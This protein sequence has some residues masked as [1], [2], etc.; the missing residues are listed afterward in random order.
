MTAKYKYF[1]MSG[2]CLFTFK[3][4]QP[5]GSHFLDPIF[6]VRIDSTIMSKALS[7][8]YCRSYGTPTHSSDQDPTTDHPEPYPCSTSPL[9]SAWGDLELP[10]DAASSWHRVWKKHLSCDY[11]R[12]VPTSNLVPGHQRRQ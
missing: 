12:R 6:S 11:Q 5:S 9:Q 2:I 7:S 10:P 3:E 1:Q 8:K 4:I